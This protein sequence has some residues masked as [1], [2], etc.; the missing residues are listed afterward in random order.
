MRNAYQTP[1]RRAI[2]A[3]FGDCPDRHFTAEQVCLVLR[4]RTGEAVGKSTVYRQ[5]SQLCEQGALRRFEDVTADGVS[6][7][8]YQASMDARC[9]DHFHLKCRACGRIQHL[10]CGQTEVLLSHVRAHHR[11]SVDC[12]ESVLVGLCADCEAEGARKKGVAQ[13]RKSVV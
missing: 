12:G 11:F 2:L 10:E 1:M 3:L 4:E 13:D 8:V 6:V 9:E 5:L 7:R